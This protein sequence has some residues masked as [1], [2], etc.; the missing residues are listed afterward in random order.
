MPDDRILN[1]LKLL[2]GASDESQ[3]EMAYLA[4]EAMRDSAAAIEGMELTAG[5]KLLERI[6]RGG[7]SAR[8]ELHTQLAQR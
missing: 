5:K 8:G 2:E 4:L 1:F 3:A 7:N 6:N